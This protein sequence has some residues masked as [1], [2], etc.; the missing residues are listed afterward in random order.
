MSSKP[1]GASGALDWLKWAIVIAIVCA[2]VVGNSLYGEFPLIYRVLALLALVVV[3]LLVAVTT[4]Q[5]AS[6]WSVLRES[7][8][9]LRKVVWPT[10]QETNQT[11][12]IVI[13]LVILTAFILWGLD[14]F[15]GWLAS[16]IIG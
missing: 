4:T 15:F 9:E 7:Q 12:L 14:A 6:I 2:G 11:S 13:L 5:G 3:A 1:E 8:T 10:R 16:L